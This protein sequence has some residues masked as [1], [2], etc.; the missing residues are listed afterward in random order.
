MYVHF[1]TRYI[2]S[3]IVILSVPSIIISLAIP[4]IEIFAKQFKG[5]EPIEEFD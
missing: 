2:Y 4:V 1:L 3:R 5:F